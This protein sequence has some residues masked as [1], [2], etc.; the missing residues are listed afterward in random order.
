MPDGLAVL[1]AQA[2]AV[3][4][5]PGSRCNY[6]NRIHLDIIRATSHAMQPRLQR[7]K[8]RCT[9]HR[10]CRISDWLRHV[11]LVVQAGKSAA[12]CWAARDS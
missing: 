8:V 1:R 5:I 9:A 11:T 10:V 12:A 7:H 3:V 2:E 4:L 6:R